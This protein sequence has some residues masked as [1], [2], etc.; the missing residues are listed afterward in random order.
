MTG[1]NHRRM[2]ERSNEGDAMIRLQRWMLGALLSGSI[3]VVPVSAH[4]QEGAAVERQ[5]ERRANR[6]AREE[7]H[8]ARVVD[9]GARNEARGA[10]KAWRG[11][12]LQREAQVA[13]ETG[14][15]AAAAALERK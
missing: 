1:A 4:A 10:A 2:G 3:G 7:A 13:A 8:G 9:K 12:K 15:P 14:H 5:G 11:E 6:G